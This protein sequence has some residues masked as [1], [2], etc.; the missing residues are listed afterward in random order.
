MAHRHEGQER[1]E[2]RLLNVVSD[3]EYS[4]VRTKDKTD[5]DWPLGI[6]DFRVISV[7]FKKKAD[8][9]GVE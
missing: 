5:Q 1:K 9:K 2:F 7:G 4:K 8:D 6:Q 3:Q